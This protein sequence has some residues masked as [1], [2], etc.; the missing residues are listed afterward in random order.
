MGRYIDAEPLEKY[1]QDR[2]NQL[3]NKSQTQVAEN[4]WVFDE[5][6]QMGAIIAK[7]FL[8][9]EQEQPTA[10]V[11]EVKHG[12]WKKHG[13]KWECSICRMRINLDGTPVQNG[14]NYCPNCGAK[15]E[16]GVE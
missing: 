16:G 7:E 15:M 10:D 3:F 11:V 8:D 4:G 1:Y 5:Y 9:K 13:Y 14:L 6:I 12:E 2:F